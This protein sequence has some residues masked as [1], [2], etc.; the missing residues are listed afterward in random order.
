M[1]RALYSVKEAAELCGVTEAAF[2]WWVRNGDV[3]VVR[4]GNRVRVPQRWIAQFQ[5]KGD[6]A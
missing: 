3:D 6:A 2:R 5:D 4:I 1:T